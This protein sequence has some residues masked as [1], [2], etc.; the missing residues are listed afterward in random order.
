MVHNKREFLPQRLCPSDECRKQTKNGDTLHLQTRG[1][2]FVKF[3]ELKLQ[4]L[5]GQVPMGHVPRSLTVH[6]RGELTRIASPG[7]EVTI[8]GVFLPQR[9]VIEDHIARAGGQV[10]LLIHLNYQLRQ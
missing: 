3:Q 10:S 4:E 9:A 6:C 1:S 7:N 2:K 5:P 8:D